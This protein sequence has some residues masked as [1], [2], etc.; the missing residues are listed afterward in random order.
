MKEEKGTDTKKRQK[1]TREINARGGRDPR[2][3]DPSPNTPP[4]NEKPSGRTQNDAVPDGTCLKDG[5]NKPVNPRQRAQ[6]GEIESVGA[7]KTRTTA[8]S[9]ARREGK[10]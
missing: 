4:E 5:G 3:W 2:T 8:S 10:T 9:K 1:I 6:S 7:K